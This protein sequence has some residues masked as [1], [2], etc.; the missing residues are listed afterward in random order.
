[1]ALVDAESPLPPYDV[2]VT[3][4]LEF[5][6]DF[7]SLAMLLAAHSDLASAVLEYYPVHD[8]PALCFVGPRPDM[9]IHGNLC[10]DFFLRHNRRALISSTDFRYVCI[11]RKLCNF[12]C[13][14]IK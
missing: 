12:S 11:W 1:M 2:L 14:S 6:S 8:R 9:L 13:S 5:V 3:G 7:E 10:L 4:I